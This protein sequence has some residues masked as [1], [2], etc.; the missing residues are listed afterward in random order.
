MFLCVICAGIRALEY[1]FRV[2]VLNLRGRASFGR[3]AEYAAWAST[4][5]RDHMNC[6]WLA[7]F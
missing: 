6:I 4:G 2:R 3:L 7:M 1:D 5:G